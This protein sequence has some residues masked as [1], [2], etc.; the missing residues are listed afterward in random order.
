MTG[1]PT[2][3]RA[4][5]IFLFIY[6]ASNFFVKPEPGIVDLLF[7]VLFLFITQRG[8]L[9]PAHLM[10]MASNVFALT[11]EWLALGS[12]TW[13]IISVYLTLLSAALY[14]L[15]TRYDFRACLRI[16]LVGGAFGAAL[17][18][19]ALATPLA[20][21][22]Y[23]HTIRFTGF[24]KDPNVA[25][26]TALFFATLLLGTKG[27]ARFLAALPAAIFALSLSR[28][29][30]LAAALAVIYIVAFRNKI[31]AMFGGALVLFVV[32]FESAV[33]K[34]VDTFFRSIGR[35]GIINSYDSERRSNWAEL[36]D[37]FFSS[38]LPLG[39]SYSEAAGYSVHS[40]YLRLL[41]EQGP[42]A[43]GLFLGAL[44][45]AWR[46]ATGAA[47][48]AALL[49]LL[50]NGVVVDTTHWRVLF[51]AIAIALASS[52][53]DHQRLSG[54]IADDEPVDQPMPATG[55]RHGSRPPA[56]ARGKTVRVTRG[57]NSPSSVTRV[58]PT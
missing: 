17:T 18:L 19:M 36:L 45:L 12:V 51:V 38:G 6:G 41:V 29:T 13:S 32:A 52:T 55:R 21:E 40:T 20:S 24:F 43:L 57:L 11:F 48:K 25:A 42:I 23:L 47:I 53:A 46:A 49:A 28:A 50:I 9:H 5:Q 10:L 27:K 33:V 56:V 8:L 35:N 15:L 54:G 58:S 4:V 22:L 14:S 39:P 31:A 44:V 7:P 37:R 30:M 3:P 34:L 1:T 16:F 26:P 2:P